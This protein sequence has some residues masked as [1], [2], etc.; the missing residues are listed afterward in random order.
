MQ[1]ASGVPRFYQSSGNPSPTFITSDV[2]AA[3][4]SL[5][6]IDVKGTK[7]LMRGEAND[8]LKARG[9]KV[10]TLSITKT[11][12]PGC[13]LLGKKQTTR[14]LLRV[15]TALRKIRF[16][17]LASRNGVD[18]NRFARI[19]VLSSTPVSLPSTMLWST[20]TADRARYSAAAL[21]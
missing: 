12:R 3:V 18:V 19:C 5:A 10:T 4:S 14:L 11:Q 7:C 6:H 9:E 17:G 21:R 1:S 15:L 16:A 8:D 2:I 13:W 20:G